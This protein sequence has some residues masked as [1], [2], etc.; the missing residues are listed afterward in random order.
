[1]SSHM[2]GDDPAEARRQHGLVGEGRGRLLR[3][4]GAARGYLAVTIATPRVMLT[5]DRNGIEVSITI[6]EG[7]RFKIRQFR[8][9]EKGH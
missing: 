8:V 2:A 7:P 3:Q 4:A 9:Y 1:M 6:D 5:P